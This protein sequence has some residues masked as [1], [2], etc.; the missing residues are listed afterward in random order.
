[1]ALREE[2]ILVLLDSDIFK[3]RR[4]ARTMALRAGFDQ[5]AVGEIET[6][7]S[8][9]ATNLIR[10]RARD[11]EICLS[12]LDTPGR[13]ALEVCSQDRGPGIADIGS[14][15]HDGR[16]SA[17]GLGIGLSGV[18]RL[19]DEFFIDSGPGQMTTVVAR[20]WLPSFRPSRLNV[21]VIARPKRGEEV[22][23]DAYFI[24][25]MRDF[26]LL[27]VIDALGHGREAFETSQLCL[28]AIEQQFDAPLDSIVE[29]CHRQLRG[30]R[31]VAAAFCRID[32][33]ASRL[34]HL[35]LGNVETRVC[36]TGSA[37]RPFCF[38]GTLGMAME[39]YQV[40]DYPW[41]EGATIVMFSDG[42]SLPWEFPVD[43]LA[44]SP[45][46]LAERLFSSYAG[47]GDDATVLVGR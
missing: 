30:T 45:Q 43:H 1:M 36:G 18:R 13:P 14:A 16:S 34:L 40:R 33:A 4:L 11:G 23:G 35:G 7:V 12:L 46:V 37:V 42:M 6:A 10:H 25:Q 47:D 44:V 15:L 5:V 19:M 3:S 24:R 17:G 28:A 2:R 38:N 20:K 29:T 26:A 31:G 8:E 41:E 22:C 21:S 9:L 27:A 32:F 39:S